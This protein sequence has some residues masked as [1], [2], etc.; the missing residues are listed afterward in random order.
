MMRLDGSSQP[1]LGSYG[2]IEWHNK[3]LSVVG[4]AEHYYV[5]AH[6]AGG[7]LSATESM[8]TQTGDNHLYAGRQ[9]SPPCDEH[10]LAAFVTPDLA[11]T[12]RAG[13]ID[14]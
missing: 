10:A 4:L 1:F 11:S 13:G 3:R 2:G 8:I 7:L 5:S 14:R 6:R 9:S 12:E